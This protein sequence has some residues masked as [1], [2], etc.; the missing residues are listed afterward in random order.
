MRNT[1]RVVLVSSILFFLFSPVGASP[2]EPEPLVYNCE[3]VGP[4]NLTSEPGSYTPSGNPPCGIAVQ[5]S[6]CETPH[7]ITTKEAAEG[8]FE[9]PESSLPLLDGTA[10][11][12]V[13]GAAE[14]PCGKI[15]TP[16]VPAGADAGTTFP[17][18]DIAWEGTIKCKKQVVKFWK[19]KWYYDFTV[20]AFI[21][22]GKY[23]GSGP[24]QLTRSEVDFHVDEDSKT[25]NYRYSGTSKSI[26]RF[27][28]GAEVVGAAA[29]A[30]AWLK[31][32][33]T[34]L[35]KLPV[36]VTLQYIRDANGD[37]VYTAKAEGTGILNYEPVLTSGA[38]AWEVDALLAYAPGAQI[39]LHG[40]GS[41]YGVSPGYAIDEVHST[42]TVDEGDLLGRM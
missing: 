14:S 6:G 32:R 8:P 36:T 37:Y 30:N 24:W 33:T 16:M 5:M 15:A 1:S 19:D 22:P 34:E 42:I 18:F 27:N 9:F 4:E 11:W 26:C 41:S 40:E 13:G 35:G 2:A 7:V 3:R 20:T 10:V 17:P 31:D 23:V 38:W 21:Q 28:Q 29:T 39:I 25:W 12:T